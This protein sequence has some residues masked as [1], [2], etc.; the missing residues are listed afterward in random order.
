MP[1]EV[2]IA[3]AVSESHFS[4]SSELFSKYCSILS[5]EPLSLSDLIAI[6]GSSDGLI[7]FLPVASWLVSFS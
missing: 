4:A 3:D 1:A 5:S 7:I 6:I 2:S